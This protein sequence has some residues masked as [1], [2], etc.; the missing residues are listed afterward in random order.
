MVWTAPMTFVDD[1]ALTAAQLNTHLRD[2][3]SEQ[4]VS[5]ASSPGSYFTTTSPNQITERAWFSQ[6]QNVIHETYSN[7]TYGDLRTYGPEV[8]LY[9]DR[10]ALVFLSAAFN[11]QASVSHI[12]YVSFEVSGATTIDP[13]DS[14]AIGVSQQGTSTQ[15]ASDIRSTTMVPLDNLEPGENV[16]TM[17]YRVM[18]GG[19]VAFRNQE[20]M[21]IP[22]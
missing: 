1:S 19:G 14:N 9:T 13:S 10:R 17:K 21:V 2:N 3:L 5:K 7:S 20:I 12:A 15:D 8:R 6:Q 11:A 16:F 22:F 18:D 4:S